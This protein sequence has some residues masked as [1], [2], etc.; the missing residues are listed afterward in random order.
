LEGKAINC[1]LL[2]N[3]CDWLFVHRIS[4]FLR[5]ILLPDFTGIFFLIIFFKF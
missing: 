5:E 4:I 2:L 3:M 1:K